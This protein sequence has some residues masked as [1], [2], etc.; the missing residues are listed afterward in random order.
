MLPGC[1][2]LAR[3]P[4]ARLAPLRTTPDEDEN[5]EIRISL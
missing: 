2:T 3:N 1:Q 5:Y 4:G